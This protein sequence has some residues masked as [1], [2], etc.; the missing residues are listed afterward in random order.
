MV[1]RI[2]GYVAVVAVIA[3]VIFTAMN[4]SGYKSMLPE[5]FLSAPAPAEPVIQIEPV[6]IDSVTEWN[7]EPEDSLAEEISATVEE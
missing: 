3:I 4:A 5:D 2:I 1:K 6:Q 7:V